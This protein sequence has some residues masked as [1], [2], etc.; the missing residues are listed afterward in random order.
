MRVGGTY[1]SPVPLGPQ[2]SSV[3]APAGPAQAAG[4]AQLLEQALE[5]VNQLQQAA[6]A[7]AQKVATGESEDVHRA[8]VAMQEAEL[9]LELTAQ[10]LQRALEAYKEIARLPV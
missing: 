7:E 3:E 10:V 5:Q 8:L 4:F 2:A 6:D 1:I 9:A